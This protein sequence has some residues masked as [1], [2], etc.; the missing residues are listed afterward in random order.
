M[1]IKDSYSTTSKLC[2]VFT[3][4]ERGVR[5][6][7]LELNFLHNKDVISGHKVYIDVDCAKRL[8]SNLQNSVDQVEQKYNPL[9]FFTRLHEKTT[10]NFNRNSETI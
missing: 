9:E 8:I 1:K 10:S 7:V 6:P 5:T 3:A 4:H 2:R